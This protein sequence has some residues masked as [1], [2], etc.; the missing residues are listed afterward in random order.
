MMKP[1]NSKLPVIMYGANYTLLGCY[2]IYLILIL[3]SFTC[4]DSKGFMEEEEWIRQFQE[5]MK[6][7]TVANYIQTLGKI[8]FVGGHLIFIAIWKKKVLIISYKQLLI[9]YGTVFLLLASGLTLCS[10]IS[11]NHF[12]DF[13]YPLWSIG[14]WLLFFLI[15]EIT[16]SYLQKK[17]FI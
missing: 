4:L 15:A 16:L 7:Q 14:I 12:Y 1:V 3:I 17:R 10:L 8:V 6:I 9:A 11:T 2:F 5:S 13:L